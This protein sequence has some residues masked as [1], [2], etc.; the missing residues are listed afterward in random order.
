MFNSFVGYTNI[1]PLIAPVDIASTVTASPYVD[2]KGVHQCAFLVLT[3]LAT[4]ATLLDVEQITV[5]A[6]TAADGTEAQID[7]RYRKSGV[8]TAN[9]WAAITAASVI[10]VAASADDGLA[11][12]IEVD[13]DGLAANDYRFVR[14][15][16]TDNPDMTAMLTSVVAFMNPRFHQTTFASATASASA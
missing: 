13:V 1:M 5:E 11:Y 15:K 12:W 9:T 8:V 14:V 4:S 3:G 2:L 10:S 6:A 16:L 7:F